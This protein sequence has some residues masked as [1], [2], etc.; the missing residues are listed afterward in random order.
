MSIIFPTQRLSWP[1]TGQI[2]GLD[3]GRCTDGFHKETIQTRR[4]KTAKKWKK[5]CTGHAS[6]SE[7]PLGPSDHRR[8]IEFILVS[9]PLPLHGGK[10]GAT[11]SSQEIIKLCRTRKIRRSANIERNWPRLVGHPITNLENRFCTISTRVVRPSSHLTSLWL[12]IF[13]AGARH[14]AWCWRIVGL[15]LSLY[16]AIRRRRLGIS[17]PGV[18]DAQRNLAWFWKIHWK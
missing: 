6:L 4:S 11:Q 16:H 14:F 1:T 18:A 2:F 17:D 3:L 10:S 12:T 9:L 13:V 8:N 7:G 5:H 15:Y